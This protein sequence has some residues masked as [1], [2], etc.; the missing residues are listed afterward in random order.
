[1][2]DTSFFIQDNHKKQVTNRCKLLRAKLK[3]G[4]TKSHLWRKG[5]LGTWVKRGVPT[6]LILQWWTTPVRANYYPCKLF[7]NVLSDY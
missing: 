2:E 4:T 1:M 3:G 7:A 5:R 6:L